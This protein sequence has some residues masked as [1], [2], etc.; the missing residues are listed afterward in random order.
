MNKFLY[1]ILFVLAGCV[2]TSPDAILPPKEKVVHIDP[3]ILEPCGDLLLLENPDDELEI[4]IKNFEIFA[5]CKRKQNNS[6][7]LLKQFSNYKD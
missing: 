7:I 1:I 4:T 2:S 3:R 6:I 5:D